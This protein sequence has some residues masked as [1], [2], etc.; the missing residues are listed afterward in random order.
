MGDS[1]LPSPPQKTIILASNNNDER[2]TLWPF[3][4][5]VITHL[6]W[7]LENDASEEYHIDTIALS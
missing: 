6:I 7:P 4:T 1:P 5:F 2:I 3:T